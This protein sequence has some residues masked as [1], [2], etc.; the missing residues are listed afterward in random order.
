MFFVCNF[1]V[2]S[3]GGLSISGVFCMV[4]VGVLMIVCGVIVNDF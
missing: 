3:V 4:K 2:L 1:Y